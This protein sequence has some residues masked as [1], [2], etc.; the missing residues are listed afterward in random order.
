MCRRE[1]AC[2]D[3]VVTWIGGYGYDRPYEDYQSNTDSCVRS[4]RLSYAYMTIHS[5]ITL[6]KIPLATSL[7]YA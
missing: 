4:F 6:G 2:Y 1:Q 5:R 3:E 7:R